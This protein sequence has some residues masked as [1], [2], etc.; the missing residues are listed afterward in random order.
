MALVTVGSYPLPMSSTYVGNTAD[1][2]D[3]GRNV[4]GYVIGAV[5]RYDVGKIEM[6]WKYLTVTEWSNILKL[7]N[8]TYGGSFNQNVTFYNQ[9]TAN[10]ETRVFYPGDRTTAGLVQL[11]ASGEPVG[12]LEAK[13]HLVEV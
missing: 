1:M 9:T 7:F 4:S 10:Y 2:V 12:W 8:P 13:L 5:V 6:T 11:S 3:A